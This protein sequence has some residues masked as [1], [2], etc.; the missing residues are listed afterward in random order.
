MAGIGII[1]A[2]VVVAAVEIAED[3]AVGVAANAVYDE[4]THDDK[5]DTDNND[6]DD[7]GDND[8]DEEP[9]EE[10]EDDC[11]CSE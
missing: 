6:N 10:S 1:A 5:S 3:I 9:E 11:S 7:K 4:M 8:K 2:E